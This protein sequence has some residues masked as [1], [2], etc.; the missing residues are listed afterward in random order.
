MKILLAAV[1][2]LAMMTGCEKL[3]DKS[4]YVPI[5]DADTHRRTCAQYH[6]TCELQQ[7]SPE[8]WMAYA[9]R[10]NTDRNN[11][12]WFA[13]GPSRAVAIG[14]LNEELSGPP[15]DYGFVKEKIN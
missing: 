2:L 5:A 10:E 1:C 9:Y 11:D 12:W 3:A 14:K 7:E 13:F 4:V 8:D 6:V 15:T